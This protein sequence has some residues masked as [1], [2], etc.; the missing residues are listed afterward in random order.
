[1]APIPASLV[2]SPLIVSNSSTAPVVRR[3]ELL[4]RRQNLIRIIWFV[5]LL[6]AVCLE[7]LGRRYVRQIPTAALY[8]SKDIV[9]GLGLL[10]FGIHP[11][12]KRFA[13]KL[14]GSAMFPLGLAVLWTVLECFNPLQESLIL[15]VIGLRAYW[16]WWLAPLIVAS[17]LQTIEVR[18]GA[19]YAFAGVAGI[20]CIF[21]TLQ[22]GAPP[23]S[24]LN[25]YT[26]NMDGD[27]L[28]AVSVGST[29]RARV[30]STFS[31]IT[32][33]SDFTIIVPA[34]LLT[35]GLGDS[36]RKV[37]LVAMVAATLT[38]SV[39]PMSGSRAPLLI[40]AALVV[41]ITWSAG[42]LFTKAG[43]R[44]VFGAFALVA[45]T[46]T[47][48]PEAL[49]GVYD[50]MAGDDSGNRVGETLTILPPVS[51]Q[52][53]DYPPFGIGTGMQQNV[54]AQLGVTSHGYDAES[55]S[56]KHLIEL[57]VPGYLLFW[58]A[59]LGICVALFKASRIL[60]KARRGA[61]SG[62]AMGFSALT[63]FGNITFDHIWQSLFFIAVGYILMETFLANRQLE[64]AEKAKPLLLRAVAPLQRR[65]AHP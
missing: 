59:R 45:A 55:E 20:V 10:A 16:L 4:R 58:F 36:D 42:F 12:V 52:M 50:R 64:A 49:Q 57:G 53:F 3:K 48:F 8:F 54:R 19:V 43:R 65:I 61:A 31:F 23:D 62:A 17:V 41:I 32:G 22:F 60:R 25:T 38:A 33:F 26:V 9:L 34:L 46:L 27:E 35:I 44:M 37:R 39:L 14:Y 47:A 11:E 15:A 13:R 29:G 30:A 6:S 56:G 40:G 63:F 28:Q 18:R 2:S 5:F 7:G 1:M 24:D 51:L 21:A